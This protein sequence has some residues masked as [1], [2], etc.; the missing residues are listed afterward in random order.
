MDNQSSEEEGDEYDIYGLFD[1]DSDEDFD[2]D[3]EKADTAILG[4][5]ENLEDY[6]TTVG[7]ESIDT[8]LLEKARVEVP[9]VLKRIL[10]EIPANRPRDAL[11]AN[12]FFNVWFRRRLLNEM[13][14]W[15][16]R[17]M[18]EDVSIAEIEAFI[19]VELLLHVFQCS[20]GQFYHPDFEVF[21]TPAKWT[22]LSHTRFKQ[23]FRALNGCKKNE[24][25]I[26]TGTRVC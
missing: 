11:T 6:T 5:W 9:T 16:K 18:R 20:P 25:K 7:I 14:E 2:D 12:D 10:Q 19:K 13:F 17:Y 4:G 8:V 3:D 26:R 1:S 24:I 21:Y 22:T 15:L 23:I